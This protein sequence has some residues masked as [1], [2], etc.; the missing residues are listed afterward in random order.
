MTPEEQEEEERRRQQQSGMGAAIGEGLAAALAPPAMTTRESTTTKAPTVTTVERTQGAI[1]A[2]GDYAAAMGEQKKAIASQAQAQA[3]T[4]EIEAG[5]LEREAELRRNYEENRRKVREERAARMAEL[6]GESQKKKEQMERD[7]RPTSYWEDR[8]AAARVFSAFMVGINTAAGG[9]EAYKILSENMA[10]DRQL[11]LDKFA[12]SKELHAASLEGEEAA[13]NAFEDKLKEIGDE[14]EVRARIVA[15]EIEAKAK[16]S[17]NAAM[18]AEAAKLRAKVDAD[19]AE[20]IQKDEQFYAKKTV[21]GGG[22]ST[23][24]TTENIGGAGGDA[25]KAA[26]KATGLEVLDLSGKSY[27]QGRTMLE[28]R[29]LRD[30]QAAATGLTGELRKLQGHLIEEGRAGN[31]PGSTA[32]QKRN[33]IITVATAYITRLFETGV[34]NKDEFIRYKEG[35]NTSVMVGGKQAAAG[36][37]DVI[38]GVQANFNAKLKVMAVAHPA[39]PAAAE[40]SQAPRGRAEPPPVRPRRDIE[41]KADK[42]RAW[43]KSPEGKKAPKWEV[44]RAKR[45]LEKLKKEHAQGMGKRGDR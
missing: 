20:K 44:D 10:R 32:M 2:A 34:L 40:K 41:T 18:M 36:I 4:G 35:L 21:E 42:I 14:E 37:D 26:E 11:K 23:T 17:G 39:A 38:S 13:K 1:D 19:A 7:G 31:V 33:A 25:A 15:K 27:G 12:A 30:S 16:R 29:K 6:R 24:S 45:A 3:A 28:A 8:G 9:D 22:S 43:L 5:G